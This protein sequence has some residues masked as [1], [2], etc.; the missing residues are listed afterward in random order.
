MKLQFYGFGPTRSAR[1][2]GAIDEGRPNLLDY[3]DRLRARPACALATE[4]V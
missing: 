4:P 3:T 1:R 2:N